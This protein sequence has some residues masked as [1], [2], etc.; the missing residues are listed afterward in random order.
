MELFLDKNRIVFIEIFAKAFCPIF[1][2]PQCMPV[3][4]Q[5]QTLKIFEF[6]LQKSVQWVSIC[7]RLQRIH[8]F[9]ANWV[10]AVII[11]VMNEWELRLS[12]CHFQEKCIFNFQY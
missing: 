12:F 7:S 5:H 2:L 8:L 9:V 10:E 3:D 6:F 11:H 4:P 1:R